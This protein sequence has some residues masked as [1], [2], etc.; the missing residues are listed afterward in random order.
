[1]PECKQQ[2]DFQG[3]YFWDDFDEQML[4]ECEEAYAEQQ[5]ANDA[6]PPLA[7]VAQPLLEKR[8]EQLPMTT[9]KGLS[10]PDIYARS[11]RH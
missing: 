2:I 3:P 1:M 7:N 8:A 11:V 10:I 5:Q 6:Q 4:Q 9:D